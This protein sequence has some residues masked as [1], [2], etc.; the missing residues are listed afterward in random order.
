MNNVT[1]SVK[2][3]EIVKKWY[4]IDAA[5]KPLG[6]VATEVVKLLQGKHKPT[7][8][9]HIDCG[10]FVIVINT[11]KLVLTGNKLN[12]KVHRYHTGYIGG[13]KEIS[14]KVMM[15]NKSDKVLMLA[16]KGMFNN[17]SLNRQ[18]LTKLKIFKGETHNHEAQKPEIWNY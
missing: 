8:S 4:V 17:N 9:K 11:D 2:E 13:E 18:I 16:V 5:G 14:Y 7:F 10:D 12:A 3:S 15:E 6:R 1:H